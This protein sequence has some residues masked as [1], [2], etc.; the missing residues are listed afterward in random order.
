[1]LDS[2]WKYLLAQIIPAIIQHNFY[3]QAHKP[4]LEQTLRI[5]PEAH[6]CGDFQGT[7]FKERITNSKMGVCWF[8]MQSDQFKISLGPLD[9]IP[10]IMYKCQ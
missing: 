1:M 2:I 9:C 8:N 4:H 6:N 5:C 7:G 10:P 3:L